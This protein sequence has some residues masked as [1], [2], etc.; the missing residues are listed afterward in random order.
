MELLETGAMLTFTSGVELE[1]VI[2][3]VETTG[4]VLGTLV[5]K[6]FGKGS[7]VNTK[8]GTGGR[9]EGKVDPSK[10][11]AELADVGNNEDEYSGRLGSPPGKGELKLGY[12]I[13]RYIDCG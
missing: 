2:V 10:V 12:C 1:L 7:V 9:L 5:C 11:E 3:V 13:G 4:L 6:K 8:G